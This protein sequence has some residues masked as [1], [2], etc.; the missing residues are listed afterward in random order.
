MVKTNKYVSGHISIS[1]SCLVAA[2]SGTVEGVRQRN[3]ARL[4]RL[5]HVNGGLSRAS[6]TEAT[7]LNRS[8]IAGLVAEL[9]A[10]GLVEE[11]APDPSRRVGRP[12]PI[13]L[14]HPSI[15][16]IAANPEVDAIELGAIGLDQRLRARVRLPQDAVL[17]PARTAEIVAEQLSRWRMAELADAV[18][19]GI[20]V[21]VPGLVRAAD[22]LVRDAPHLRWTDA[23]VRDLVAEATGLA[24][25]VGNDASLGAI[26]EHRYGAA[27]GIDDVVYL[28]GGASGIGGGL[29]VHGM[30]VGGVGG[31][32][33]EFG[34]N[35]PGIAAATDQRA[36]GGVLED[37]VNRGRLLASAGLHQADDGELAAA[38]VPGTAGPVARAEVERQRRI[39]A[40]ALAN[41]VNVL[42]PAVIVLG[43]FLAI[44]AEH[45]LP[46]LED[47]V[48][49]QSMPACGEDVR[50]VPAALAEDRLLIGAAEAVF[51]DL[52]DN[53]LTE[54][55]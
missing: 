8:T 11:R 33:G 3:L 26:A 2:D 32:A 41:A 15:V 9:T 55:L 6:L 46:G 16:A 23:P 28:N 45:D 51:T 37:E 52:I 18:V 19:V 1:Y 44:L 14:P 43:G 5:V 42:N 53:R 48:R 54:R 25:S 47:A 24:T 7:G 35:R 36:A 20:G 30:P 10:A 40:T 29:I 4:V 49:R 38:L 17:T 34:Q 50:I 27:V 31:Y 22:G 13:V 12:S 21:A 39:L